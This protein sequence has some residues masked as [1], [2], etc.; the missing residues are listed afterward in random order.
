[1]TSRRRPR[2][3]ELT[4]WWPF[5]LGLGVVGAAAGSGLVLGASRA[6]AAD[7]REVV[8]AGVLGVLVGVLSGL[9]ASWIGLVSRPRVSTASEVRDLTGLPVV[10]VLPPVRRR[11]DTAGRGSTRRQRDAAR[12]ALSAV[13]ELRR[14]LAPSR[15][16]LVRPDE[17]AGVAGVDGALAR[18]AREVG[19]HTAIL[20]SDFDSRALSRPSTVHDAVLPEARSKDG[21]GCVHVPVPLHVAAAVLGGDT[22][23]VSR[24]LDEVGQGVDVVVALASETSRPL[25]AWALAHDSD[26]VLLVVGE[27]RT[28]HEQLTRTHEQLLRR[29]VEPLGVLLSGSPLPRRRD[30]RP[31]WRADDHRAPVL[32]EATS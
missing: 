25:P 31:G 27:G 1:V 5:L 21:A 20:E 24:F 32:E 12:D 3:W 10:G 17:A 8:A 29:G 7:P 22:A 2:A 28:T 15:L 6:G 14:G 13:T 23:Q 26:V 18:A 4:A 30:P 11:D 9:V 16:L 19:Y